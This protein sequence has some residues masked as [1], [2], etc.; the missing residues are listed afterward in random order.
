MKRSLYADDSES[1]SGA[2][3]ALEGAGRAGAEAVAAP[4]QGD[5]DENPHHTC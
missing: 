2:E 3:R 4:T 1:E 5:A